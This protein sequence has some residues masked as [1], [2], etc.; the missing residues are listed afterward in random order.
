[1]STYFSPVNAPSKIAKYSL[2][3]STPGL[4]TLITDLELFEGGS[5]ELHEPLLRLVFD[6]DAYYASDTFALC[7]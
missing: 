3:A 1:M 5:F 4:D 2:S 6:L 7:R